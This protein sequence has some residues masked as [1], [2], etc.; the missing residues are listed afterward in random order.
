VRMSE[1]EVRFVVLQARDLFLSEPALLPINEA[2]N[3]CGDLH[4]QYADLLRIFATS[5]KPP[6]HTFLFLGDYVDRGANSIETIMLLLTLKIL[7]PKRIYMLRGNHESSTVNRV[8]GFYN[9]CKLRYNV[10][11]WRTFGDCFNCLPIA[12]VIQDRIFCVHG[13]L[14][15]YLNRVEDIREIERPCEVPDDGLLTDLLW[16]DPSKSAPGLDDWLPNERG[17][18]YTFTPTAIARFLARNN[19]DLI[20]RAHQVVEEGYEF[21]AR[22]QLVT[23]FSAPNY[24]GE[25][26][27][28]AGVMRVDANL[29]CS[30]DI[31]PAIITKKGNGS[32]NV[33]QKNVSKT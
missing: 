22:R 32:K 31:I 8:Y 1:E 16:S 29:V 10:K 6:E 3:V 33:S 26:D 28:A 25:F 4:G 19:L 14:S 15:P 2:V 30:F 9:E 7:Y 20:C 24:C 21:F 12:A 11:V 5:G 18:S 23:I 13:G 27:N 17:V